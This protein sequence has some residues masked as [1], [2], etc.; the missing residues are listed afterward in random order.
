TSNSSLESRHSSSSLAFITNEISSPASGSKSNSASGGS[1]G[2][3]G[4]DGLSKSDSDDSLLGKRM[5]SSLSKALR[6][7]MSPSES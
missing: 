4:N 7:R 2:G 5:E 3:H 1:G 6:K